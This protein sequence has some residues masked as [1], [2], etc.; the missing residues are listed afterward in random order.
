MEML[1]LKEILIRDFKKDTLISAT[2]LN[3][4]ILNFRNLYNG[5]LNFGDI[6]IEDLSLIL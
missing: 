3:T 4:S 1:N 6:D 2:E 5:K